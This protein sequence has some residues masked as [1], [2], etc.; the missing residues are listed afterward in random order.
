MMNAIPSDWVSFLAHHL[1]W[2]ANYCGLILVR[3][4]CSFNA[5]FKDGEVQEVIR[6]GNI[7]LLIGVIFLIEKRAYVLK[8]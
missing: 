5:R 4:F 3:H 6:E 8:K 7:R 1:N 2:E